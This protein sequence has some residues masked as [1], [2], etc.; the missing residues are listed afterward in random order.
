MSE[1]D[2][3]MG[4]FDKWRRQVG[5]IVQPVSSVSKDSWMK[6]AAKTLPTETIM[7]ARLQK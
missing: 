3:A 4:A 7:P 2:A 5:L 1:V 6:T